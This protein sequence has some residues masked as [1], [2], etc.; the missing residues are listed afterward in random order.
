MRMFD[1]EMLLGV[2]AGAMPGSSAG[3]VDGSIANVTIHSNSSAV[4]IPAVA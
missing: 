2:D 4:A 1:S 3:A